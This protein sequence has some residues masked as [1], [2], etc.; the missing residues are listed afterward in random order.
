MPP[1]REL[2]AAVL[3]PQAPRPGPE[4]QA[5]AALH[6]RL[7]HDLRQLSLT[8]HGAG[9]HGRGSREQR[10]VHLGRLVRQAAT[11]PRQGERLYRLVRHLRPARMLEL[12]THLGFSAAYLGLG[13]PQG[14][15][16]SIEGDPAL[17]ALARQHLAALHV[18]AEVKVGPF[19][20]VLPQGQW[21]ATY[22]PDFV[23]LDGNHRYDATLRYFEQLW[24]H[25]PEGSWLLLDDIYWSPGMAAAW[26]ALSQ[27][28]SV[29]V[30]LDLYRQGLLRLGRAEGKAH[31]VLR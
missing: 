1:V 3:S 28:P 9:H 22:R 29:G 26:R 27:H 31:W 21:L 12:G 15:L 23:F 24:P 19:D 17:A 4:T 25:M 6:R 20:Q 13:Q 18:A 14:Q 16:I 11:P 8:D 30:S 7:Q 5:I 10:P 2:Y